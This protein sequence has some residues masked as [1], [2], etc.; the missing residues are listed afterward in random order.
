MTLTVQT[1]PTIT[2]QPPQSATIQSGETLELSVGAQGTGLRYQWRKDGQDIP[3]A[4]TSTYRKQNAQGSDA[5]TYDVIVSNDCG[6][7]TSQRVAVSILTTADDVITAGN[8]W[9]NVE[10]IP[11]SSEAVIRYHVPVAGMITIVLYD[12]AGKQRATLF[13]GY[14]GPDA[15]SLRVSVSSLDLPS[16]AY[17]VE[18]RMSDGSIVRRPVV[19]VR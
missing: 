6:S 12:M 16:G 5:G 9:I 17:T 19:V 11:I 8:A 10:P 7:V 15:A 4:T 2:Q 14:A 1:P 13:S 3:G 18:L